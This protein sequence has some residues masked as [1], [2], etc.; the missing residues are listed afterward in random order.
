MLFSGHFMNDGEGEEGGLIGHAGGGGRGHGTSPSWQEGGRA[1]QELERIMP[2]LLAG[3]MRLKD[4]M[5]MT[6]MS[7]GAIHR[8]IRAKRLGA[9]L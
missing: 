1:V 5:E 2:E 7:Y 3:K 8:R 4:A 6:K 9:E